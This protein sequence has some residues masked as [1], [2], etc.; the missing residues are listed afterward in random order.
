MTGGLV[1]I[2]GFV[3]GTG[4][5]STVSYYDIA[6][7]TWKGLK[8]KLNIA[9]YWHSACTLNGIVYV[10]CGCDGGKYFLNSIE[11]ISESS[12]L[13]NATTLWQLINVAENILTKRSTPAVAPLNDTEI[14][15]LGG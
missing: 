13:A 10:F 1:A 9:R 15:I 8:A 2:A 11:M 5:V 14:A 7:N 6:G 3:P 4:Y 12:L